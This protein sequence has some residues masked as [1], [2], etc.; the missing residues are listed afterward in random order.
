MKRFISFFLATVL[1]FSMGACSKIEESQ[2]TEKVEELK[3]TA[4]SITEEFTASNGEKV[5]KIDVTYPVIENK[6]ETRGYDLI[7]EKLLKIAE[8]YVD[9]ARV[10]VENVAEERKLHGFTEQRKTMVTIELYSSTENTVSFTA[11]RKLGYDLSRSDSVITAYTFSRSSGYKLYISDLYTN[12]ET[13]E[14]NLKEIILEEANYSYS[15][16]HFALSD[17]QVEL[18]HNLFLSCGFLIDEEGFVFLY[19]LDIMSRGARSG[20]YYCKIPYSK[21]DGVLKLPE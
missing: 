1:L 12:P 7:N 16:N 11:S 8:D 5:S 15:P 3:I 21:S 17:W 2:P 10:N 13:G 4:H 9:E 6:S 14:E 19:S 20:Y 18:L